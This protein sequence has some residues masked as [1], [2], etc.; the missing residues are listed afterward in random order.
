ME[1]IL[2]Y[3]WVCVKFGQVISYIFQRYIYY[4]GIGE[5]LYGEILEKE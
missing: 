4:Y 2:Q 5:K 1:G 3:L